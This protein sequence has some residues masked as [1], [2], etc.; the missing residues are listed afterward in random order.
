MSSN[1]VFVAFLLLNAA[2]RKYCL[3]VTYKNNYRELLRS[4]KSEHLSEL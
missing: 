4:V 1:R 3:M 2:Q